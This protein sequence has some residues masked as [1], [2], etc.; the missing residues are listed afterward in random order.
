[1]PN[2]ANVTIMKCAS[3]SCKIP[4]NDTDHSCHIKELN[5]LTNYIESISHHTVPL[6]INSIGGK[7]T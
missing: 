7:G 1:M 5:C 6:I 3:I 4:T 2:F